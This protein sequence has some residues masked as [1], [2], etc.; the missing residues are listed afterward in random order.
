MKRKI[1]KNEIKG[2]L[3]L[4]NIDSLFESL[5]GL[6]DLNLAIRIEYGFN[7]LLRERVELI[8]DKLWRIVPQVNKMNPLAELTWVVN[9]MAKS[10]L[11]ELIE[12]Y[13]K[14]NTEGREKAISE[15]MSALNAL[16]RE[17]D[18]VI[19]LLESNDEIKFKTQASYLKDKFFQGK[20]LDLS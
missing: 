14:L 10:Y 16:E 11:P 5:T 6:K 15:T 3:R 9:K 12:K 2:S 1:K 20:E 19:E 13:L 4:D 7:T 18:G 17:I 8:I